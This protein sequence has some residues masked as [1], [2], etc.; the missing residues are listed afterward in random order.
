MNERG[1]NKTTEAIWL[2]QNNE[3]DEI[4]YEN[5]EECYIREPGIEG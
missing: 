1:E 3:D 5:L 2:D 4:L